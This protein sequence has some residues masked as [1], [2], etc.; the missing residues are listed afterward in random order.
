MRVF[1]FAGLATSKAVLIPETLLLFSNI[2]VYSQSR[3]FGKRDEISYL[4]TEFGI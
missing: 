2:Y 3:E 1:G 4:S